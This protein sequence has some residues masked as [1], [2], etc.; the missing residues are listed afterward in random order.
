MYCIASKNFRGLVG[1]F[2]TATECF[3]QLQIF[4]DSYRF[5]PTKND[6]YFRHIPTF[7]SPN[8][9]SLFRYIPS[10]FPDPQ[11]RPPTPRTRPPIRPGRPRR[12]PLPAAGRLRPA[13]NN[14]ILPTKSPN[15]ADRTTNF[16]RQTPKLS[17]R[18]TEFYRQTPKLSDIT[19]VGN[20]LTFSPSARPRVDGCEDAPRGMRCDVVRLS[21]A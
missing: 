7:L 6:R 18:T 10:P 19:K 17:D 21:Y 16:Y 11:S 2:P 1:I 9:R 15:C 14:R 20:E 13:R 3:R 12:K 4:S 5:F 8:R